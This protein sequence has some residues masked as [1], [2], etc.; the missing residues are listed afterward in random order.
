M[1]GVGGDC[2]GAVVRGAVVR[3]VDGRRGAVQLGRRR[4]ELGGDDRRQ[5]RQPL[6]VLVPRARRSTDTLFHSVY[7]IY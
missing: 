7:F 6:H 1:N 3:V 5:S 4:R 2:H